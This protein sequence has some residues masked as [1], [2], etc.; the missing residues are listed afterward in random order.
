MKLTLTFP[1]IA[2]GMV[3]TGTQPSSCAP[4]NAAWPQ[5]AKPA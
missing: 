4:A 1:L 3:Q 2:L 5:S